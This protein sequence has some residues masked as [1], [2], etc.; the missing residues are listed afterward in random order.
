MPISDRQLEER[1]MRQSRILDGALDVF[2]SKGLDGATMDEIASV[3]GFGKGT[4][5][6][7]FESKEE[8]FSAILK[9]GWHDIWESLEPIIAID[10]S[11]RKIFVNVLIRYP[12]NAILEP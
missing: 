2:K 10:D 3:A 12:A 4:L 8:V 9:Q 7:Y 11:P 1:K 5:Y 6:Y